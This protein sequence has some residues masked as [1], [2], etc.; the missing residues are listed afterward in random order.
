MELISGFRWYMLKNLGL[1]LRPEPWEKTGKIPFFLRELYIFYAISLLGKLCVLAIEKEGNK[2]TPAAI[3]KH[4]LQIQELFGSPCIYLAEDI[5]YHN[6]QR[7]IKHGVPFV[8][9]GRQIHLPVLGVDW[10]ERYDHHQKHRTVCGK[11][12]SPS[13]QVIVIY[14]IIFHEFKYTIQ[15]ILKILDYSSMTITRALNELEHF[16]IGKTVKKGTKR[17]ISLIGNAHKLWQQALPFLQNP[18][19]K[20]VWLQLNAQEINMIKTLG[21]LAGLSAL[22][23]ISMLSAPSVPI[24]ALSLQAWRSSELSKSAEQLPN[25]EGADIELEI[26]SYDPRLF[27]KDGRVDSFSLWLSLQ[28][29]GDERIEKMVEKVLQEVRW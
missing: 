19:V 18:V 24:Y 9:P 25:S 23:Q 8:I 13:S 1:E 21:T 16:D 6:R 7:L 14:S 2:L 27:A 5:S 29:S 10:L 22:E 17:E 11:Q 4:C 28:G 26:W 3:K 12:L 15:E 20:R